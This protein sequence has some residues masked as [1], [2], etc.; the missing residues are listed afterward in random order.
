LFICL[1][2]KE[3]EIDA[4]GK[5]ICMKKVKFAQNYLEDV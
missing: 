4:I 1:T 3:S 5:F 2:I